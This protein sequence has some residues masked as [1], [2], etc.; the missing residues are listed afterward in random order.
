MCLMQMKEL[1]TV[2]LAWLSTK[3]TFIH[4]INEERES[5]KQKFQYLLLNPVLFSVSIDSQK[6]I[7][8]YDILYM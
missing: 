8:L 4:Y 7:N 1:R 5:T 2:K 6:A 3:I